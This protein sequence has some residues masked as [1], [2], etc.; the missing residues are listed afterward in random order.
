MLYLHQYISE[1]LTDDIV[2]PFV[3]ESMPVVENIE[4]ITGAQFS[5]G[6]P[7]DTKRIFIDFEKHT[8]LITTE[9]ANGPTNIT[10]CVECSAI[11]V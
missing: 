7:N 6:V 10:V 2:E 5:F 11:V 4:P 1:Q 8:L 3:D 9:G